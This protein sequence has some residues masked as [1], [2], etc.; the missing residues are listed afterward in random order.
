V[1][2]FTF[3]G[4][5][6]ELAAFREFVQRPSGEVLLITGPSGSGKSH[7]LRRMRREADALQHHFVLAEELGVF[8]DAALRHYAVITSLARLHRSGPSHSEMASGTHLFV[9]SDE[10]LASLLSEERMPPCERLHRALSVTAETLETDARLVALLDLGA[11]DDP[12]AFPIEFFARSLPGRIK[13]VIA[14]RTAPPELAATAAVT[15]LPPLAAFTPDEAAQ[16]FEFNLPDQPDS[17]QLAQAAW[18]TCQGHPLSIDLAAKIAASSADPTREMATLQADPSGLS[19]TLANCLDEAQQRLAASV[20]RVPA[21]VGIGLLRTLTDMSD[22]QLSHVIRTDGMRNVLL[23]QRTGEGLH[24]CIFHET[25]ADAVVAS[26]PS[27][28]GEVQAFH[29]RAAACFLTQVEEDATNVH[30]LSAHAYHLRQSA[31]KQ[32]FISDFPRTYKAKHSFH[33]LRHLADEYTRL[34]EYCRQ[35]GDTSISL[36][37]CLANLGRVLQDLDQH[38]EAIERYR[39]ALELCEQQ[40]DLAGAAEQYANLASAHQTTGQFTEA[41][42]ELEQAAKL[43]EQAGNGAGLAADW[44]TLGI[45]CQELGQPERALQY[46][47]K[48]LELHETLQNDVGRANQLA[49]MANIHRQLGDLDQ[50]RDCYQ[51]AWQLDAKVSPTPAQVADLCNL[52]VVFE[53]LAELDKALSCYEQAIALDRVTADREAEATHLRIMASI[54]QRLGREDEALALLRQALQIDRAIGSKSGETADLMALGDVCRAADDLPLARDMYLQATQFTAELG[55]TDGEAAA[56]RALE[57]MERL[58]QGGEIDEPLEDELP[59]DDAIEPLEEAASLV[60]PT[61]EDT[62]P[63]EEVAPAADAAPAVADKGTPR[64]EKTTQEIEAALERMA[65]MEAQLHDYRQVVERLRKDLGQD[66][67]SD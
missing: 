48:A 15:V 53:D 16:I 10:F 27:T 40:N 52:G 28:P 46:H 8:A 60:A 66:A 3:V 22:R 44:N 38:D 41:I 18:R 30:A 4:R 63:P 12:D 35:L 57:E 5:E 20:A 33:L 32:Q 49:N 11:V 64:A 55:D 29:K 13:L 14:K 59:P 23:T 2:G 45:I 36:P 43:D 25:F 51:Q 1:A 65:E 39:E 17:H 42:S 56:R 31:D 19:R 7:L 26:M 54:T 50:A 62:P 34:I 58:L 6:R 61:L 37:M 9:K 67:A 24:A 21:G 47:K